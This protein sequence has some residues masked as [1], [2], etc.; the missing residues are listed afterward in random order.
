YAVPIASDQF[1]AEFEYDRVQFE[2]ALWD[3]GCDYDRLRHLSYSETRVFCFFRTVDEPEYPE[4][5]A[6]HWNSEV[7]QCNCMGAPKFLIGLKTDL[8]YYPRVV[9]EFAA[10]GIKPSTKED[11][12]ETAKRIGA[13]K[14]LEC[15]SY[16]NEGVKEVCE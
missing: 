9:K 10:R 4:I 11:G 16:T 7:E 13:V 8:R 12:D 2:T 6:S 1:P 5:V 14:Y 15:S 3:T